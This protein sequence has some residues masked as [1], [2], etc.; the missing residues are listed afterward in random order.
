MKQYLIDELRPEDHRLIKAHLDQHYASA[1]L[2]GIYRV[3]LAPGQ[4][5]ATQAAH[6]TCKP[7]FMA[8]ELHPDRLACELL[9]RSATRIRCDCIAY[10]TETQRDWLMAK[11]DGMLAQL[12]IVT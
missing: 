5:T 2:E 3:M 11:I 9:V 4:L 12:R 7:H 10:A 6:D 8:L 1:A